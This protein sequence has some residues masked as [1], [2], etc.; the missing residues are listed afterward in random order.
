MIGPDTDTRPSAQFKIV[1]V[2]FDFRICCFPACYECILDSSSGQVGS[3]VC[4]LTKKEIDDQFYTMMDICYKHQGKFLE[5]A[6]NQPADVK[7]LG[8]CSCNNGDVSR[9]IMQR[10][11]CSYL[12]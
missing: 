6:E 12:L 2:K 11:I 7:C 4:S 5:T 10:T 9:L 8:F 1:C 3:V